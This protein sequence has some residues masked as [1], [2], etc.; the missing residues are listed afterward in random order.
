[1]ELRVIGMKRQ[2]GLQEEESS[3][4]QASRPEVVREGNLIYLS[5]SSRLVCQ[6]DE[7]RRQLD[8]LERHATRMLRSVGAQ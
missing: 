3:G 2:S 7:S 5:A 4:L 8:R 6:L 1:M